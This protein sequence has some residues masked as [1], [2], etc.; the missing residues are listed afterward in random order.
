M[1]MGLGAALSRAMV[2]GQSAAQFAGL[3]VA[4]ARS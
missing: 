2:F 3:V 1:D 4:S